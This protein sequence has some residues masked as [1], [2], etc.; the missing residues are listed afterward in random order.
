VRE[1]AEQ[2]GIGAACEAVGV[3][4]ASLYRHQ[5]P[6]E[7]AVA[8]VHAEAGPLPALSSVPSERTSAVSVSTE[9]QQRVL[10][11]LQSER[12]MDQAPR[13]VWAT[14]LDEGEYLCSVRTMYRL[15]GREEQVRERRHQLRHPAYKKPE[16]LAT[17]PNQVWSWD[18]T[19][20]RGALKGLFYYLY[21]IIDIYSRYVVG[22]LLAERECQTLAEHRLRET[23]Q[24]QG[25]LTDQLT[26]HADRGAPM[27]SKSVA[28]LLSDLGVDQSHSRPHVCDDNP[29]SESQ[30]KTLKYSAGFPDRFGSLVDARSFCE[31]FFGWYNREHHHTGIALLTPEIVHYG[32]AQAVLADRK[33]T[34]ARAYALHPERFHRRPEPPALPEAVWINA[35]KSEPARSEA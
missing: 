9:E 1:V 16:L 12:F 7:A 23:C 24:K 8:P 35:P 4:R 33:E 32:R 30:F 21:V 11:L 6:N 14:L 34:L 17:R 15:L 22:W 27:R 29:Y 10:A 28:L 20:L 2:V 19:K 3:S 26:L 31:G 5:Q 25:I 18:I 13:Q